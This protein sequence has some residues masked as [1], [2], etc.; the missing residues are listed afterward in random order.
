MSIKVLLVPS[1]II[2]ILIIAIGYIKP[3]VMTLFLL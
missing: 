2:G 1:L 3:G